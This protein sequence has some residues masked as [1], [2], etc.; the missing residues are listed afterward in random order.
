MTDTMAPHLDDEQTL[1]AARA[2]DSERGRE[3]RQRIEANKKSKKSKK[4]QPAPS[5]TSRKADPDWLPALA[6]LLEAAVAAQT[7][8]VQPDAEEASQR[9]GGAVAVH[10][11]ALLLWVRRGGEDICAADVARAMGGNR[12]ATRRCFREQ[13]GD[14][15]EIDGRW[16]RPKQSYE[17]MTSADAGAYGKLSVRTI[18]R[19]CRAGEGGRGRFAALLGAIALALRAFRAPG[20]R[21][22]Q[23]R[24]AN[25]LN[26]SARTVGRAIAALRGEKLLTT[27]GRPDHPEGLH[28][29]LS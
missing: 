13:L 22:R 12:E 9:T 21:I 15:W 8:K 18:D 3:S 26:R 7:E 2:Y 29:S 17:E 27:R 28:Y 6:A 1:A 14:L 5:V 25:D 24:L 23:S 4:S 19:L 20:Q 10:M 11:K 16:L